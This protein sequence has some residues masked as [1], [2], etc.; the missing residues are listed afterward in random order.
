LQ[1]AQRQ[2]QQTNAWAMTPE[3]LELVE[4]SSPFQFSLCNL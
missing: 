2:P 3:R 4:R 1:I